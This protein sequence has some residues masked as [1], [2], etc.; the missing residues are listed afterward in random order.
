M[1]L[2]SSKHVIIFIH[3]IYH[4]VDAFMHEIYCFKIFHFVENFKFQIVS[5]FFKLLVD[6]II[7]KVRKKS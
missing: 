4:F 6:Q 5:N 3:E 2:Y 7:F 1:Q